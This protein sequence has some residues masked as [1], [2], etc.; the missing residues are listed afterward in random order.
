MRLR[1]GWGGKQFSY[2]GQTQLFGLVQEPLR[3]T[4]PDILVDSAV[5]GERDDLVGQNFL[6]FL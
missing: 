6:S 5:G 3:K 4:F 2:S 1:T